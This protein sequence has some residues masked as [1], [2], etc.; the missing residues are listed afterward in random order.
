M[1][2][3]KVIAETMG[4]K[5]KDMNYFYVDAEQIGIRLIY[6]SRIKK[7]T[8]KVRKTGISLWEW[9]SGFY[10]KNLSR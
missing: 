10:I 1:E 4:C 5:K 9:L 2:F 3:G 8:G 7:T 6:G